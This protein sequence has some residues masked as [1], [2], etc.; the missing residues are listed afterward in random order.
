[1][2]YDLLRKVMNCFA[3]LKMAAIN[4]ITLAAGG[5]ITAAFKPA[6]SL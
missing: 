1:M 3:A 2:S 5:I 4:I 6:S